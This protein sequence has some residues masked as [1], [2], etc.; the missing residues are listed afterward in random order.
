MPVQTETLRLTTTW[1]GFIAMCVGMF[2]AILDVQVVATSIA[3]I[4]GSV[5]IE[6]DRMSWLQTVYLIAEIIAIPL[7]GYLTR[8]LT[9]RWLFVIAITLFCVA[10]IGCA[11]SNSFEPLVLWRVVQGF[12]GGR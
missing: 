7:T 12:A 9:G 6:P 10:S 1:L 3:A 8:L 5:G 2:M 11:S 4:Q